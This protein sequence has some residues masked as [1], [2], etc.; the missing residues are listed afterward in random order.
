MLGYKMLG[1]IAVTISLVGCVTIGRQL[2]QNSVESIRKGETTKEEVVK[3]LWSPDQ[4]TRDSNG[5]TIMMYLY[6][7]MTTKAASFI[8]VVG[9]FAGGANTQNQT[10]IIVVGQNGI[11]SDITSSQG[12]S[13]SGFGGS[14]GRPAKLPDVEQNKRSK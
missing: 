10:V 7:R 8:P 9:M 5:N 1:Y 6:M 4:I 3:L 11:V 13:E 2:D 12:S 14:A